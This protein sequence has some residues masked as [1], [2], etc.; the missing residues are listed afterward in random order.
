[1]PRTPFV[2]PFPV[3]S[4]KIYATR[5]RRCAASLKR[6][7]HMLFVLSACAR[8]FS[9]PHSPPDEISLDFA[10]PQTPWTLPKL[11]VSP[12]MENIHFFF[13]KPSPSSSQ[14]FIP[15]HHGKT[16]SAMDHDPSP[17]PRLHSP[18]LE[19]MIPSPPQSP[20]KCHPQPVT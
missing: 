4:S 12:P 17:L 11:P 1:M 14:V 16:R 8:V 10:F 7:S 2:P 13:V 5:P 9:P 19:L 6:P 3:S 15:N 20:R 18:P